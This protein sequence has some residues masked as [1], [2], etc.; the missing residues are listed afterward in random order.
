MLGCTAQQRAETARAHAVFQCEVAVL[1]PYLPEAM[2]VTQLVHD[3]VTGQ[4]LLTLALSRLGHAAELVH[5]I[6]NDFNTCFSGDAELAPLPMEL[7]PEQ[8]R[9]VV[10]PPAYGNRIL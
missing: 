5:A 7:A 4:A 6:V 10:P 2:D 3:V 9:L 8:S 1:A